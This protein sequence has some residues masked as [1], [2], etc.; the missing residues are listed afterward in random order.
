M[1]M[2]QIASEELTAG[3]PPHKAA[4]SCLPSFP[5]GKLVCGCCPAWLSP[6][7]PRVETTGRSGRAHR[8]C[9]YDEN[10][11]AQDMCSSRMGRAPAT[12]GTQ[13]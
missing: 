9:G 13:D 1:S 12:L 8:T 3:L 2:L 5:P 10:S 6:S 11:K 7:L 4:C